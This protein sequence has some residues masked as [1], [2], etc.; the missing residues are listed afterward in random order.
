MTHI[1]PKCH[2]VF[3]RKDNYIRHLKRKNSCEK[4]VTFQCESCN[5]TFSTK[6]NLNR[7]QAGY[8]TAQSDTTETV[9]ELK[10]VIKEKDMEMEIMRL[11]AEMEKMKGNTAINH[12]TINNNNNNTQI[13]IQQSVTVQLNAFGKENDE[14]IVKDDNFLKFALRD[15]EGGAKRM[16]TMRH[17]HP[18]H[19]ENHNIKMT[20]Y[21]RK[22]LLIYDG[23]RW[24]AKPLHELEAIEGA[25]AYDIVK[26]YLESGSINPTE[27]EINNFIYMFQDREFQR[28]LAIN[29]YMVSVAAENMDQS[30]LLE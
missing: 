8:C 23:S 17:F 3:N 11:K 6:S 13:N 22:K 29:N 16:F 15:K 10:R 25:A 5:K 4:S 30:K 24:L 19:P 1:C 9:E 18:D 2:K 14:Y 27:Q 20:D 12:G 21:A 26:K 28:V 7:H